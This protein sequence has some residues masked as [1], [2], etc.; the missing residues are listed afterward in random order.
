ML[1]SIDTAK[2][3][4]TLDDGQVFEMPANVDPAMLK[5]GDAVTITYENQGDKKIVSQIYK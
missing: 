1:K 3:T 5:V 4:V 2:Q